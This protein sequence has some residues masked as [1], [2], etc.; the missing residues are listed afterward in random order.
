MKKINIFQI[1]LLFIFGFGLV[2]GV[3]IFSGILPGF[4]KTTTV[5]QKSVVMW[6]DIA[7][8]K[9]SNFIAELNRANKDSFFVS[10]V[11]KDP[12][13]YETELINAL[14]HGKG[15][16]L[17]LL[18]D[19]SIVKLEKLIEPLPYT[20]LRVTDFKNT[21]IDGASVFLTSVG[22]LAI[23]ISVDP[24]VMYYN[25]DLYIKANIF[26]PPQNWSGFQNNHKVLNSVSDQ[27]IISQSGVALGNFPN[28]K[29]AKEILLT[30]LM[31]AGAPLVVRTPNNNYQVSLGDISGNSN[32]IYSAL[33][34]FTR[35]ATPGRAEYSWNNSFP[36]AAT[37]F[38]NG[39]TANYFGFA[40]E[41]QTLRALNPNLNL[42]ITSL[43]QIDEAPRPLTYGRLD[44]VAVLKSSKNKSVAFS[45]AIAMFD[46]E[47][48]AK[49]SEALSLASPR[50]DLLVR[51]SNDE[52]KDLFNH[53]AL[54]SS[55][56]LDPNPDA[57]KKVFQSSANA[58]TIGINGPEKSMSQ[59]FEQ[60]KNL[61]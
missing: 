13:T 55:S 40:S 54:I 11:Y 34:F 10:Y 53:S 49:L 35:F 2:I 29:N 30:L 12:S 4:K 33:D 26:Q 14:A 37:T 50:K 5:S 23:P 52:F 6:G 17:I 59:M 8:S 38:T 27:G 18:H 47:N 15:P 39:F 58:V 7:V 44:G 9:A 1:V 61:F 32:S 45:V 57:S 25:K 31:Q 24:L 56:W 41:I 42:A 20:S 36:E 46:R 19:R 48:S 28:I 16:D 43:P 51:I 21:F 3:L 60:L 22:T